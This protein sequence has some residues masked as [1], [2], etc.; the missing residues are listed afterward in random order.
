M[1]KSKKD[2]KYYIDADLRSRF[3]DGY[4][5]SITDRIEAIFLLQPWKFQILLRKAEFYRNSNNKIIR[6]ILGNIY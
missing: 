2:L 3:G 5:L 1:I 6:K 4:K